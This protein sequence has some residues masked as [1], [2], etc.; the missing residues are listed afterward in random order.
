VTE[1]WEGAVGYEVYLRSFADGDGDGVGD[2]RGL[3]ARLE[4]LAWLGVDLVWLTPFYPS[5]M[6]DHGYDV[7][8]Y[9]AVDPAF[10]DL[11]AFDALLA[12]AHGLGLRVLIDVVPNHTSSEHPWFVAS[13][14]SRDDPKRDWYVWRDPAPDGGPPNNWTSNFGGPAW[15][16]DEATGQYWLHLFLPEQ[17]DLNWRNP[18]VAE[19]F[20][21]VLRF[22]L[23]RGVDGFRIDVAHSLVKDL[24]LRDN[25]PGL[26]PV[27]EQ[28]LA[29][30][31]ELEAARLRR[32]VDQ[33]EVVDVH[34]RW[35][36]VVEAYDAL[37]VGE[38][39]LLHAP[40]LGR[41]VRDQ[42]G[43]HVSFWFAPLHLPWDAAPLGAALVAAQRE[44]GAH[45]G[46]VQGS[47]DQPRAASRYGGGASG[48]ARSLALATLLFGLPGV[49]FVY[50]GEELGLCD[51]PVPPEAS[52]DPLGRHSSAHSRD[53]AR[54]PMPWA[55]EPG[56]GFT[57]APRAWLPFGDR[58]PTD[59]VAVQRGDPSS[60][61]G[62][63]Q[64]LIAARRGLR[65]D[66]EWLSAEGPVLAYRRGDQAIVAANCGSR[67]ASVALAPGEWCVRFCTRPDREGAD[68]SG[69][70]RLDPCE[71]ALLEGC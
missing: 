19:A 39:Y 44:L 57:T 55:P 53:V 45:V 33:D 66:V 47:H 52:Q 2:L 22:W 71:A 51:V 35:R 1:W 18:A 12:A 34:A 58:A 30:R 14:S 50:Y 40:T 69:A 8:D 68:V 37:L 46:W 56:L 38:V 25:P 15:T 65:G 49:P 16:F 24:Q 7:A 11:D 54:T 61:L 62:R 42:R 48:R 4:Y 29:Q 5:P 21:G 26:A 9:R 67:S 6:R 31:Q 63:Y 27:Y 20:D 43:V 3:H 70:L 60:M 36:A 13:R 59:T 64:A 41:Y 10:G 23:D 17:P 28:T 32:D